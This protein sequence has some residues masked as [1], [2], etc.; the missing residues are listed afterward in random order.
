MARKKKSKARSFI[1]IVFVL[2]AL[3]WLALALMCGTV[4]ALVIIFG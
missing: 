2:F 4:A 1:H 3:P